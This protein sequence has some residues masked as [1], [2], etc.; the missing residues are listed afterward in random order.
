MK[1]SRLFKVK[2]SYAHRKYISQNIFSL[3]ST[4]SIAHHTCYV[5]NFRLHKPPP[6]SNCVLHIVDNTAQTPINR[7]QSM[8]LLISIGKTEVDRFS[9]QMILPLNFASVNRPNATRITMS[10]FVKS[11]FHFC[12]MQWVHP[13]N[14]CESATHSFVCFVSSFRADDTILPPAN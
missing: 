2:H 5:F 8:C 13:G 6:H 7:L 11:L 4:H 12:C 14:V 3:S 9:Y 1:S 10:L